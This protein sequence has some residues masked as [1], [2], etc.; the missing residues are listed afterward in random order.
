MAAITR[1]RSTRRMSRIVIH[2]DRVY[3][4][5][6]T[7]DDANADVAD[8]TRQVVAK[9]DALL[10]EAGSDRSHLLQAWIWLA[11]IGDF[12]AMNSVWDDWIDGREP[13]VRACVEARLARPELK[14]E[15]QVTAVRA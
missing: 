13:P 5:G 9:I 4:S 7:A 11:D 14:V 6:L 1:L 3:L 8:Q 2:D 15:I 12:D 10:G